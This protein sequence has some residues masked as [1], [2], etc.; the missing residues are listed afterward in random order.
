LKRTLYDYTPGRVRG[1]VLGSPVLPVP[2]ADQLPDPLEHRGLGPLRIPDP[3]LSDGEPGPGLVES[4]VAEHDIRRREFRLTPKGREILT[5][6]W[7]TFM[8]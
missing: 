2:L 5:R 8:M 3:D 7:S 4:S 1:A 6:I